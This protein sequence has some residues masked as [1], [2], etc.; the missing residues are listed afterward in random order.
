M[1]GKDAIIAKIIGDAEAQK[2][3]AVKA[4]EKSA[5][6]SVKDAE[7]WAETFL[8]DEKKKLEDY[9]KELLKRRA[10]VA[11]LEVRKIVLSE[12]QAV[13]TEVFDKVYDKLCSL[14]K[15]DYLK[16]VLDLIGKYAEEGDEIVLSSDKVLSAKDMDGAAAVKAKRLTVSEKFGDFKGG[17]FL[18]GKKSD[19][20]LT[21]KSV[22]AEE[23]EK[24]TASVAEKLFP[25]KR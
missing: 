22:V 7:S 4:A 9:G 12:K 15:K 16:F 17:V 21:F 2:D 23:K 25:Q 19:K 18:V 11:E 20:D 24:R 13:V 10:T 3:G 1:Q 8:K 6:Q 14:K 5:E